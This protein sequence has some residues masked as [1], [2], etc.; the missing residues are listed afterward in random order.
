MG[1]II[2]V[3]QVV[4][5]V[6]VTILAGIYIRERKIVSETGIA[7]MKSLLVN[8]CLPAVIFKT[9]YS[10]EFTWSEALLCILMAVII[11]AAGLIGIGAKKLLKIDQPFV[12]YLCT[13]IEGGMLGFAL[14]ILLFGQEELYH[15]ALFDLGNSLIVFLVLLTKLRLRSE[16]HVSAREIAKSLA[17]PINFAIA[18]G[19]IVSISGFGRVLSA[20]DAG[21]VLNSVLSLLSAPNG[22]LILLIVGFGLNLSDV[23]W[24]ETLKTVAARAVIFAG[25]GALMYRLVMHL[26]PGDPLYGYGV[27]MAFILPPSFIYSV[28]AK[29]EREEAYVGAVLAVY[30]VLT[31]ICYGALA[32]VAA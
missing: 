22:T 20:S 5:P 12:P 8:L 10:T 19:L 28:F 17:T 27:I 30:T 7:D 16:S 2:E 15:L 3:L 31:L 14:F 23:R 1:K 29:G 18:A 6:V 4:L 21:A 25:F 26:V 13:S 32:W 9:F 11:A 24:G